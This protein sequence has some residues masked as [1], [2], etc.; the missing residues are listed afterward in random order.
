MIPPRYLAAA[1]LVSI[2]PLWA[3]VSA[4]AVGHQF[5]Q[6]DWPSI[7]SASD[8]SAW[9][10]WLSYVG[11]R[12]DVVI[13]HLKNGKWGNLQWVKYLPDLLIESNVQVSEY[14]VCQ[15]LP[16][17]NYKRLQPAFD[18]KDAPPELKNKDLGMDVKDPALLGAMKKFAE[19][20]YKKNKTDILKFLEL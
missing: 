5:R 2:A 19:D 16:D 1:L 9:V 12:D 18:S 11:D 20:F 3:Q 13:R 4:T 10:A 15:V 8:G 6:D 14:Y 7:A 17:G